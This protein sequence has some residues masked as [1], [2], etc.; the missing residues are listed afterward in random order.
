MLPLEKTNKQQLFLN[1]SI[2]TIINDI[3]K[4]N[5]NKYLKIP[6]LIY[7]IKKNFPK[8]IILKLK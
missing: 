2:T 4:K 7:K 5:Q 6:N 3:Q 8:T 1:Y